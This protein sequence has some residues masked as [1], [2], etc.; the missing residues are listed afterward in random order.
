[1]RGQQIIKFKQLVLLFDTEQ[2][3]VAAFPQ[4]NFREMPH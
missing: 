2:F 4:T 1:M 3:G